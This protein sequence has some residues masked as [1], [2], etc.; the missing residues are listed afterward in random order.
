[1]SGLFAPRMP[2]V[3]ATPAVQAQSPIPPSDRS[4]AETQALA[5]EQR[6]RFTRRRGR[7][8]TMLSGGSATGGMSASRMLGAVART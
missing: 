6:A 2:K 1:M 8:Y 5:A 3:S 4:D 7:A